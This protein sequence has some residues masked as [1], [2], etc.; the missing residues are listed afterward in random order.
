MQTQES[1][2]GIAK[3]DLLDGLKHAELARAEVIVRP[4][5]DVLAG[6]QARQLRPTL[7]FAR[8]HDVLR[9]GAL[10]LIEVDQLDIALEGATLKTARNGTT[11]PVSIEAGPDFWRVVGLYLAEGHI[12][13]DGMRQ[14]IQWSFN[15]HGE[16]DLVEEVRS[17]WARQGVKADVWHKPTATS[18]TIS[19]RILAGFW[20]GVL[21]VG[22]NCNDA[23]LP[24]QIWSQ[25]LEHKRALLAGYWLGDGSWSYIQG[26]P[27]VI[28]E[29]GTTSSDLA[30]GLLRLLADLG[31][32][33]SMRV[34]RTAKS[35][36]DTYWIRCSGA[37]QVEK[38]L[39]LVPE[40]ERESI[41]ASIKE[42]KKRIAPTGY[43][44]EGES[45]A[46]VRVVGIKRRPFTGPVYSLEVPGA[47]TFVTTGGLVTHNC[48]PKDVA[49]LAALAQ[50]FDYHPELLHAVMDINRDQRMLVIDK[51][52]DCLDSLH[53]RVIGLLGLAFKPNTDDLRE[54]PSLDIARVL[55]AA[56]ASVRAYDPAAAERAK[57]LV[58]D[59]DCMKD[60][61]EVAAGADALVLVTEWDEF[62]HLDLGRLKQLMRRP[63]MV[64]GRNIY[65]PETMRGFGF[66]YRGIGRE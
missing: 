37:D 14:R 43:R 8:S 7:A 50:R 60:A 55:L 63:V 51:L 57:V 54:A 6:V 10:R 28:L 32:V 31:V 19:S 16:E 59:I 36:R 62:H 48:F 13:R 56:G 1:G 2:S 66:T 24:D 21:K 64:D 46:W 38:L 41:T 47:H 25:P 20:L 9:A 35:T 58:P 39:D 40:R 34:G 29:C 23:R 11:V 65:D 44:R 3:F 27:S 61:Y 30:D 53:G 4:S 52:R 15:H 17:F 18:V 49:A 26:G 33:A 12:S 5:A 45:T 22:R 42:Q